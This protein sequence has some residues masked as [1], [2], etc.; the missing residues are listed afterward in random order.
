MQPPRPPGTGISVEYRFKCFNGEINEYDHFAC[1]VQCERMSF[2]FPIQAP[3]TWVG[4][5]GDGDLVVGFTCAE[6]CDDV[7]DSPQ[8]LSYLDFLMLL[9]EKHTQLKMN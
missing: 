5:R 7:L 4:D 1:L 9:P 6:A 3:L 2:A 8:L